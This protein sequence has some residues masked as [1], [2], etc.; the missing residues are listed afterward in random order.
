MILYRSIRPTAYKTETSIKLWATASRYIL[1]QKTLL[2]FLKTIKCHPEKR[3]WRK[4]EQLYN[5]PKFVINFE[6]SILTR[7]IFKQKQS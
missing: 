7:F 5:T 6:A 3:R 2:N 4:D 1:K